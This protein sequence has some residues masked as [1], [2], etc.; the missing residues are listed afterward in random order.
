V[1]FDLIH[2]RG[3]LFVFDT[4]CHAPGAII[5]ALRLLKPGHKNSEYLAA[6]GYAKRMFDKALMITE[7]RGRPQRLLKRLIVPRKMSAASRQRYE[8]EVLSTYLSG[9]FP[10]FSQEQYRTAIGNAQT[11]NRF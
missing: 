3:V 2:G 1:G 4:Y 10:G 6:Y 8:L 5:K 7:A 11:E 9:L